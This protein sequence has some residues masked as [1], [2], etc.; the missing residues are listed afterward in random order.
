MIRVT[1]YEG[2]SRRGARIDNAEYEIMKCEK[3][4]TYALYE[5]ECSQIYIDPDHLNQRYIYNLSIGGDSSGLSVIHCPNCEAVNSF[6]EAVDKD[7]NDIL[8]SPWGFTLK[9]DIDV[10]LE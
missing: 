1:N 9:P 4:G 5:N 7:L 6:I 2:L 3:C 8:Q 10:K